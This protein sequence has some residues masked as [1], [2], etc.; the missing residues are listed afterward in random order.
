MNKM[1]D[2][3]KSSKH[4]KHGCQVLIF[5]IGG[6]IVEDNIRFD[7][8]RETHSRSPNAFKDQSDSL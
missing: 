4:P 8:S 2:R 6:L 5:F 3:P 1:L 7:P